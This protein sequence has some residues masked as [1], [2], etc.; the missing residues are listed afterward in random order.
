MGPGDGE[1]GL[2]LL[3][4]SMEQ[5]RWLAEPVG[6]PRTPGQVAAG[7]DRV[8]AK[9]SVP[10]RA[11]SPGASGPTV[12]LTRQQSGVPTAGIWV[13]TRA[14]PPLGSFSQ[15]APYCPAPRGGGVGHRRALWEPSRTSIRPVLPFASLSDG[16]RAL[17]A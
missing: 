11:S 10:S 2:E 16:E 13:K 12:L 7:E 14:L 5:G 9:L 8:P 15:S 17:L 4:V 6:Q 1:R 3:L